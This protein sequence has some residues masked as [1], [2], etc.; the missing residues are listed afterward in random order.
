LYL[1][2]NRDPVDFRGRGNSP[3]IKLSLFYFGQV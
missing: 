3:S 1:A 2:Y